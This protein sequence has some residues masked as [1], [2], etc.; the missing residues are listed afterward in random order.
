MAVWRSTASL[1]PLQHLNDMLYYN[2]CVWCLR[3]D[4]PRAAAL[5][6]T[7]DELG[8]PRMNYD[9]PKMTIRG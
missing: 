8:E 9:K 5:S 7:L 1:Q 4:L 2:I 3:Q 6:V